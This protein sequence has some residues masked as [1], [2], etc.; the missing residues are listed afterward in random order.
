[1]KKFLHLVMVAILLM[2]MLIFVACGNSNKQLTKK[3]FLND[4]DY[5]MKTMEDT[6]PYFGVAERR[7]GVDIRALGKETRDMIE[8]YPNS[9]EG[10]A[11]EQGIDLEDMPD[12]D[13][14][15]FWSI[16]RH[17][18]F[19][20]FAGLA[21][22]YPLDSGLYK[23]FQPQYLSR[24]SPFYTSDNYHAFTNS[25]SQRFYKEQEA[26]FNTLVE[27]EE[28]LFQ[29]IFRGYPQIQLT[30]RTVNTEI[31]E[32]DKIAYLEVPSFMN[33]YTST[34]SELAKFYRDIQGYEH[35]IIDIRDNSGGSPDLWRMLI[36][37]PLWADGKN[38]PDMPLFAFHRGT[39]LG[40][41]LGEKN[42]KMEGQHT[43][44]VPE[45]EHLLP[46]KEIIETNNLLHINEDDIVDLA[47][48]VKFNTSISNIDEWYVRQAGIL[49]YY[50]F[51]GQIWLLTNGNNFS[52][53]ALFARHAKEMG[54]ATLVGEE[55]GGAYTTSSAGS[56]FTLP[57]T[58]I[59]L[60]WDIDYLTDSDGRALNEFPTTPHHLNRPGIDALE[61]VLQLIEED[62]F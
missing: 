3:D 2:V 37:K 49:N 38:M 18:F 59:I 21:H 30:D 13:E 33:F 55:T 24:Q 53:S 60:R 51:N 16:I 27:E 62:S 11:N 54:F 48:G 50:P 12:L 6:F 41:S 26:L 25:V 58:G 31:I 10:Y 23:L 1:M 4:F 39:K 44:N 52:G 46:A 8:N 7:F 14:H 5:L 34:T 20:H 28:A 17:E 40:K 56:F 43:R 9:L 19:S 36:M 42:L 57:K 22:A 45:T 32:E 29:F 61:T 47:Y 35:L 15:I